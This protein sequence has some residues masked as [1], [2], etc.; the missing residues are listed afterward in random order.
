VGFLP[1]FTLSF[2]T[3]YFFFYVFSFLFIYF[4]FFVGWKRRQQESID[5][6]SVG[7]RYTTYHFALCHFHTTKLLLHYCISSSEEEDYYLAEAGVRG[8]TFLRFIETR[9]LDIAKRV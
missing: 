3:W 6:S 2:Q 7:W 9:C 1:S 4:I 8:I 5:V